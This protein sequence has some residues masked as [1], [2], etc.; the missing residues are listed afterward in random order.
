L[1]FKSLLSLSFYA[2]SGWKSFLLLYIPAV[3]CGLLPENFYVH[4]MM[5]VKAIR[6]LLSTSISE[7]DIKQAELLLRKFCVL[8][9]EYYGKLFMYNILVLI[10]IVTHFRH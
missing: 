10:V 3:L 8:Y 5:L 4:A 9:E 1:H 2:A 7:D 6:I